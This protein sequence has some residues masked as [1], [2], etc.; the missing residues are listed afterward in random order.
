[1]DSLPLVSVITP[2]YNAEKYIAQTIESVL[3]QTYPQWEMLVVDNCSS[4]AS[5]DIVKSF[6][7]PRIKLIELEYNSG[8]PARPRNIG[9]EHAQG[10]YV[11]FLDADDIWL[12]EKLEKQ[13]IFMKQENVNFT[14]CNCSLIDEKGMYISPGLK[15]SLLEKITSKKTICDVI[16]Y[17]FILTSSVIVHKKILLNF[18]E[19]PE[20]ISVEDFDLWLRILVFKDACYKYQ[21]QTLMQYR[22]VNNSASNRHNILKQELKANIVLSHFILQYN[23][24]LPCYYF[25][26][27]F[28]V[29]GKHVKRFITN[30]FSFKS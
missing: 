5:K 30:L 14:S 8:G 20:Y 12:P 27:F 7:D 23:E 29:F 21:N 9:M 16:K 15:N 2:L 1:M 24:Y 6:N 13:L 3:S 26:F 19:F 22:V 25:R 18:N 17:S 11:A 28:Y 10:E 4:D